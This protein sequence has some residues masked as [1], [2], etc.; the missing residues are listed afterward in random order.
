M[1]PIT[2]P[3]V[4]EAEAEAA[5]AV[6]ISGWLTQGRQVAAFESEFAAEVGAPYACAVS[7]AQRRCISH[8][9]RSA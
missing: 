1:I 6:V 2:A 4:G 8:C 3:F 7:S 5:R 9:S